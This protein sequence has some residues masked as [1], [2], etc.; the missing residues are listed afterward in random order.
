[1]DDTE[2]IVVSVWFTDI[3]HNELKEKVENE[4]T[5]TVARSSGVSQKAIDLVFYD[6]DNSNN[7]TNYT[8]D[9]LV[10]D[11]SDVTVEDVKQVVAVEREIASDMYTEH[12]SN[13]IA[14]IIPTSVIAAESLPATETETPSSTSYICRYA[15]NADL[16][17]TKSQ[18]YEIANSDYV[19]NINYINTDEI[20]AED[21]IATS[22]SVQTL[23]DETYDMTF[24]SVTGLS[25]ARDAFG[26]DGTGMNVGMIEYSSSLPTFGTNADIESVYTKPSNIMTYN[27]HSGLVA[28][29]MVAS[30]YDENDNLIFEGAI[31]NANLFFASVSGES[32]IK[33]ATEALLDKQVT[34]INVSCSFPEGTAANTF[35]TYGDIAKWY[36]YI[37]VNQ[38]VHMVISAGNYDSLGVKQTNTSY[39]SIVVGACDT[40]GTLEDYSSYINS[41][42]NM[43]KPDLVAPGHVRAPIYSNSGTSFATPLVTSAVIQLSQYSSVLYSNPTL[44]KSLLLG[45]AK[46]TDSMNDSEVYSL[47]NGTSSTIS[48]QYGAGMLSVTNAYTALNNNYYKTGTF[49]PY[50]TGVSY[51]KNLSRAT[52]KT[53]RICLN[54]DK[55]NS[56]SAS[57]LTSLTVDNLKLTVTTP[58]G[59]V[60]SS[61]RLYDNKQMISFV[62]TENGQYTFEIERFGSGTSNQIVTYALSYSIQ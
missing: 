6:V 31:P 53:I 55:I 54:W 40:D 61:Q 39:N 14:D 41:N 45:S 32:Q 2:S 38:N 47:A 7:T 3:D 58:S 23:S 8:L 30:E 21:N 1:M 43:N 24:Q 46:I 59:V 49:S 19:T 42:T 13:I 52:N 33:A 18:I 22:N 16:Y 48:K 34:A 4:V 50:S 44:M 11:Y 56:G 26:L 27:L 35:N 9:T 29:I 15:P 60:Y 57:S 37:T 25:V 10:E 5:T 20:A 51:S 17:L 36:D 12:N 28:S 62:A